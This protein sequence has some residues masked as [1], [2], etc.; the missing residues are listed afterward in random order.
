VAAP[1]VETSQPWRR[2]VTDVAR[3]F[4][5]VALEHVLVDNAAMQLVRDPR[6]FDVIVTEN[7]LGTSSQTKRG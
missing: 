1:F 2:I 3:D 6:A 4:P 5:D 7:M